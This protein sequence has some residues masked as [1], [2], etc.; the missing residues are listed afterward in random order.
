M[1][2][3]KKTLM[4]CFMA[5][6]MLVA[7][8]TVLAAPALFSHELTRDQAVD[9][10]VP[11]ITNESGDKN[12]AKVNDALAA[13]VKEYYSTFKK[14]AAEMKA[15]PQ[16]SD[17]IKNALSFASSYDV[18]FNQNDIISVK[19]QTWMYMGGAHG[20]QFTDCVT[21]DLRTGKIYKL[22]DLFD[23]KKGNYKD[24]VNGYIK[25]QI[26][27]DKGY[28]NGL[29][30]KSVDANTKFYFTRDFLFIC[31]NHYELGAYALGAPVFA[32]PMDEVNDY[33]KQDVVMRIV[34]IGAPAVLDVVNAEK[35]L[36]NK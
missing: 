36:A 1:K 7:A 19:S 21:A 26:A 11:V 25:K 23:S 29:S 31:Y 16:V 17:N 3:T 10:A 20:S 13:K 9:M 15:S 18:T 33:F 27:A 14:E 28:K 2:M 34:T 8:Q 32:I 12:I 5:I 35:K 24:V 4:V 30:F 22:P 6:A